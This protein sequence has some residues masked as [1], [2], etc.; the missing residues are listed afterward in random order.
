MMLILFILLFASRS[1]SKKMS[2]G[3][4]PVLTS[5]IFMSADDSATSTALPPYTRIQISRLV[6]Q[7]FFDAYSGA[8]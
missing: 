5:Q 7:S 4:T 1:P 3:S 8:S 2:G 6:L